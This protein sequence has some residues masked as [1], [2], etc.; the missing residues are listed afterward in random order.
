VVMMSIKIELP[1]SAE[2]RLKIVVN[3]ILS[4]PVTANRFQTTLDIYAASH[5]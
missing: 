5:Q 4:P 2:S 3:G 1:I